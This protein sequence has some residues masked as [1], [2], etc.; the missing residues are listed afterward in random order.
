MIDKALKSAKE[1]GQTLMMRITPYGLAEKRGSLIYPKDDNEDVPGWYR[2]MVGPNKE[3]KVKKWLVEPEDPRYAECFGRFIQEFGSRYDGHPD[4]EAVDLAI[5][6]AWGEGEGSELLSQKIRETLINAYSD[7]FKKTPLIAML[8]DEKT[9]IYTNSQI[10]AG[11]RVDCIGDLGL[12]VPKAKDW[13]HRGEVWAHMYDSYPENI[14]YCQ[15]QDN[16]KKSPLSFEICSTF[17][18]WLDKGYGR[19]E[20]KYIID[21][22]L[23][24]HISSFNAKSSPVPAQWEDLINDW[25]KKMGYRF[26]LR[27][28]SYPGVVKQNGKLWF[29]TWWENK[30]VAPCYKDFIPAIR[31][32]SDKTEMVLITD[33]NIKKWL[34]GDIIYDD[35]VFI[36]LDFPAGVYDIQIALVDRLKHEPRVKLA[37]TGMEKDGWYQLG[38]IKVTE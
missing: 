9:N 20:V 7:N 23:K 26:V 27:R 15:V 37:I 18:T 24:W 4:L 17:M 6:G 31:L 5:L 19:E 32:K 21:Q 1:R 13:Y 28:F 16:W 38:K 3:W 25:L 36:S 22:T 8:M 12:S 14:F 35:A 34:P 30:G 29:K 2:N 10:S 33:T 11:W